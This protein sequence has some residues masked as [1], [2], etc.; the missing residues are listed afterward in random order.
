MEN[1]RIA[2]FLHTTVWGSRTLL[3]ESVVSLKNMDRLVAP[4]LGFAY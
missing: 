2:A 3:M 1:L 4:A